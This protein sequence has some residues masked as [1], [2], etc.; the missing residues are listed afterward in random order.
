M[1][2]APQYRWLTALSPLPRMVQEAL[3]LYG[4][5]EAPGPANSSTIMAWAK[6]AGTAVAHD[7]YADEVPWCGLF[8]AT[9]A[10]RA[11]K[12]PPVSPLWALSWAKF[13]EEAGQPGLGDVLVFV[14]KGGGHVGLYIGEDKRAYH[15]LGG[16]Q[17]DR[18]CIA[19]IAKDRLYAA[20]RPSYNVPPATV[21]PYLLAA[22]GAVSRNEA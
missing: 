19:R 11:G 16:N 20:R 21:R 17:A 1:P 2:L 18:V 3:K 5:V 7:Y 14:R 15:V 8:L 10:R 6:E 22:T 4:T 13:G 12:T 9:V